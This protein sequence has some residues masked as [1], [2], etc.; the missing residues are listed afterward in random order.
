MEPGFL[1]D[2]GESEKVRPASWVEGVPEIAR[3]LGLKVGITVK[4]KR[5][6]NVTA[7]RCRR[8]GL[9]KLYA[10]DET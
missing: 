9:L 8:C 2:Y 4:G 5:R 3:F 6:M 1:P 10:R 7:L